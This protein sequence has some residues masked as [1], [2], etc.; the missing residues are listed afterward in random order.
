[1]WSSRSLKRSRRKRHS[2]RA[3][4][5]L[6]ASMMMAVEAPD[7]SLPLA[8]PVVDV[9]ASIRTSCVEVESEVHQFQALSGGVV[10]RPAVPARWRSAAPANCRASHGVRR[11]GTDD[12]IW[13]ALR[14]GGAP[15][16]I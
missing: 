2:D 11:S 4:A 3:P 10:R 12:G 1:M 9:A 14:L 6:R 13:Q 8:A 5:S 7:S 15:Y 16:D